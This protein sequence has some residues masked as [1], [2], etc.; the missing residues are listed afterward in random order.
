MKTYEFQL[1]TRHSELDSSLHINN[2][3]YL[4]Y[5][6]EARVAM[7][8]EQNFPIYAVH[9]ANVEMILYKY[10]CNFKQ[11]VRYP[12]KLTVRSKQIQTK[13]VRGVL[14]Q[15]IFR[16]DGS[17]CFEADAY[18][19][20][21]T[22][23]KS[24]INKT[25]E[26][27]QKFGQNH[28]SNTP[29]LKSEKES[30]VNDS[31]PHHTI[32]IEVRP[33]EIDSFQH[34][35]NAVYANYFEI[36]RWDFRRKLF[37]DVNVFRNLDLIFVL[38]KSIVQFARPSFLFEELFVKTWLIELTSLRIIYWQEIQDKDGTIRASSRSEGCAVNNKGFP[39]KLMPEILL[40]YRTMLLP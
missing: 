16:E 34:V 21:F 13:K 35:N 19:A 15:E 25:Q 4:R 7:M 30:P 12:E 11:Q 40:A 20:Y 39:I 17:L 31:L 28:Y 37:S 26:F 14:R 5:L 3:N 36:G 22:K 23:N 32:Q 8:N 24:Q 9:E 33:Y 1:N 27:A 29:L 6:E 10:V 38:Y 18:W 2:A